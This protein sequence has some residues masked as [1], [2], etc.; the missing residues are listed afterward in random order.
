MTDLQFI[1][2]ITPQKWEKLSVIAKEV[3]LT[4]SAIRQA[5]KNHPEIKALHYKV[6]SKGVGRGNDAWVTREGMMLLTFR[7]PIFKGNQHIERFEELE[8][9]APTSKNPYLA[10]DQT[11][12]AMAEVMNDP[13]VK[14]RVQQIQIEKRQEATERKVDML[15]EREGRFEEKL[16]ITNRLLEY[17]TPLDITASQ[18]KFLNERVRALAAHANLPFSSIWGSVHDYVGKRHVEDYIFEDYAVAIKHL[19]KTYAQCGIIW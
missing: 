6:L 13:F 4:P 3:G 7:K 8:E 5:F 17:T 10:Q 16:E 1:D 2:N 9:G 11:A 12:L 18:R 19:K 14:L 15:L